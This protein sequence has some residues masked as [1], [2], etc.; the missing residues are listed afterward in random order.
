M[1]LTKLF[2][3]VAKIDALFEK[4]F[5]NINLLVKWTK[6]SPRLTRHIENS[7]GVKSHSRSLQKREIKSSLILRTELK[8]AAMFG[9]GTSLALRLLMNM[10]D[11]YS[12]WKLRVPWVSMH[13][14]GN[15]DWL[16][17]NSCQVIWKKSIFT[18]CR[19]IRTH[20]HTHTRN[21]LCPGFNRDQTLLCVWWFSQ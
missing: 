18:V 14:Y 10:H 21:V 3:S 20:T 12:Y 17:N 19:D 13:D 1:V 7:E 6:Q 8:P 2:T 9:S 5:L 16:V 4:S 11:M 15:L